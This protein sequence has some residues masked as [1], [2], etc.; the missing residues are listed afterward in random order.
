MAQSHAVVENMLDRV[1]AAGVPAAQVGKAPKD[2]AVTP[3]FT[4]LAKNGI[5]EFTA[6]HADTGY[7]IGGTAWDFAHEGRVPRGSLDLL[8]IDEA[9]QF[10]LAS[11]IAVSL[12]A[13][14]LLLLGD[15][16]QLPQVSQGTHP[17]PVDTSAL[18]WVIDGADVIPAEYGYFLARTWRMHP[19]V[20]A[21][22]STLSYGGAL[23]AHPSTARRTLEGI[24]PGLHA[25]PVRHRGNATWSPEE[26]AVV[27]G[28]VTDLI[29]RSWQPVR[30]DASGRSV[31]EPARPLS[32]AD[33]I[34][35][36]PYNA[37]QVAVEEALE[38]AGHGDVRVGTVDRF[39]GQ[40]AAVA[41]VSLAASAGRDAPR[42]L[43]FLLLRNRL[44]VAVSRAMHAAFVVYSPGLLDDLPRTP[45][46]VARLSAF[47][48][49]VGAD[50]DASFGA[51]PG[52]DAQIGSAV[53]DVNPVQVASARS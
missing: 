45:E 38:A 27:A 53:G 25:H 10:S 47:A 20:A 42:G 26:A 24:A 22:V 8:V 35:V 12:A 1:I 11:T 32:A 17:E 6:A 15:P 14:R 21:S 19:D 4:A 40:E 2:A 43:E 37:Q 16:Q 23:R 52:G 51:G 34:V 33:V 28:I 18:G 39:Q 48:R 7:V 3:S 46:G 29:G 5:A 30:T 13:S 50:P 9:G 36:T 41:I 49:L 44:N 31:S